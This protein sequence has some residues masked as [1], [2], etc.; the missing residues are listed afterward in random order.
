MKHVMAILKY[1]IGKE[2]TFSD[3]FRIGKNDETK[4]RGI[5]VKLSNNWTTRKILA[6]SN[7]M[8]DYPADYQAFISRELTHKER[9]IERN[10]LKKRR[11]LIDNGKKRT[12]IRI[13]NLKLY[14]DGNEQPANL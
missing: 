14:V 13:C 11:D 8:K 1:T 2:P 5:I 9:I 4:R 7:H 6:N 3:C 10:L 12:S